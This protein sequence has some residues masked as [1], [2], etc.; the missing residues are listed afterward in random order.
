MNPDWDGVP[1]PDEPPESW[2]GEP[3][4][5]GPPADYEP[6]AAVIPI[7]RRERSE[8]PGREARPKRLALPPASAPVPV[9]RALAK[10]LW[11]DSEGRALLR[12]WRGR[13]CEY[14]GANTTAVDR[15]GSVFPACLR[16]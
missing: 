5:E 1:L 13:W 14:T 3:E 8:R 11:T 7:D 15:C 4:Y 10:A 9:A 6:D 16:W 12:R 2:G